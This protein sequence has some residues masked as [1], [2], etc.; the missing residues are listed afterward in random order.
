[1]FRRVDQVIVA[2]HR[3]YALQL[4]ANVVPSQ[5]WGLPPV[6]PIG[7]G[8]RI[9]GGWAAGSSGGRVVN[10]GAMFVH[11]GRRV[12]MAVLTDGSP[13]H[14]YGTFTIRGIGGRVMDH[15]AS[16]TTP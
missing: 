15:Y 9:K 12:T 1:M 13:T 7:W 16:Y 8:I 14:N 3:S 11:D 6:R 10:Q 5:R 2:R 4:L